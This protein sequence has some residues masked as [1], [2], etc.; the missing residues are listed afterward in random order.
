MQFVGNVFRVIEQFQ[1]YQTKK[2]MAVR[3]RVHRRDARAH[4]VTAYLINVALA[5]PGENW[6][7]TTEGCDSRHFNQQVKVWI[8][9]LTRFMIVL[10]H[11]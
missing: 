7:A 5:Y 11:A 9:V 8:G 2:Q 6:V 4:F 3:L 10:R 1:L